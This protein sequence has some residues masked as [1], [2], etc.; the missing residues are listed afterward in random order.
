MF[1]KPFH[2]MGEG[3][4]SKQLIEKFWKSAFYNL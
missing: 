4:H 1:T 3:G 2:P